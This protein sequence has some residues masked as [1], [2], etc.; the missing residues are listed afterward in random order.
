M[1]PSFR[2][3]YDAPSLP[4][5]P[6]QHD[7]RRGLTNTL[8]YI[9]A[10][11]Y[12][13][14]PTFWLHRLWRGVPVPLLVPLLSLLL[15]FS[16]S[17]RPSPSSS[18]WPLLLFLDRSLVN[19]LSSLSPW[20]NFSF[21]I[22]LHILYIPLVPSYLCFLTLL[23]PLPDFPYEIIIILFACGECNAGNA[24]DSFRSSIVPMETSFM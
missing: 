18:F 10:Q 22:K 8:L 12:A 3:I 19:R 4:F 14:Y 5:P 7:S 15:F 21:R 1:L 24:R 17:P 11:I 16:H 2:A 13:Y 23:L 20:A 6:S 9:G